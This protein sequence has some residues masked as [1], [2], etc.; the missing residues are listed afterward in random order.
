MVRRDEDGSDRRSAGAL[1][2]SCGVSPA[3]ASPARVIAG[4]PGS[5]SAAAGEIPSVEAGR[6][7]P[8]RRE[9]ERGPQHEV[10]PA[11]SSDKQWEGRADHVTAKAILDENEPGAE[12]SSSLP[13]VGGAARVQGEAL[14]TRG[15][16][17]Q[18]SSRRGVS[19]KPKVK[20]STA[21]RESEGVI[22][23]LIST[24]NNVEGGKDLC[25]GNDEGAGK[26]EGMP[27]G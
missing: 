5:R 19:Y 1:T 26:R 21:K 16:S 8:L 2:S 6:R 12:S 22:V 3:G 17:W 24:T 10:K 4:E 7:E 25:G 18:P 9:Q 14:N 11:A 20:S 27:H 13:G 23:P 15:P